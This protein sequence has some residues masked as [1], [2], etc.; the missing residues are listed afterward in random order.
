MDRPPRDVLEANWFRNGGLP[1]TASNCVEPQSRVSALSWMKL[2]PLLNDVAV[3]LSWMKLDPVLNGV[4]VGFSELTLDCRPNGVAV[5]L[6]WMDSRNPLAALMSTPVTAALPAA[7]GCKKRPSPHAGSST[8]FGEKSRSTS[9]TTALINSIGVYQAPRVLRV[10][11]R[12]DAGTVR[13]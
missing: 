1:M 10:C 9:A 4:A 5:G 13:A 6:V 12:C 11:S 2:D 7:K 8:V 3:G